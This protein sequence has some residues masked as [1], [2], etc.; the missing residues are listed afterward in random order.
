VL[1]ALAEEPSLRERAEG[2]LAL[3][4]LIQ[5]QRDVMSAQRE[6]FRELWGSVGRLFDLWAGRPSEV[7]R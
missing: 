4:A 3:G 6:R 1:L 7:R 5:V 2:L